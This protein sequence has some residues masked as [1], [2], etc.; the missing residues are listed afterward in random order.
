MKGR[1]IRILT[2]ALALGATLAVGAAQESLSDIPDQAVTRESL[3]PE[4]YRAF[5]A[6]VV[7]R[8]T[9]D[10]IHAEPS[11]KQSFV[12]GTNG[13]H[14]INAIN[15]YHGGFEPMG[16]RPKFRAAE[17]A[18]DRVVLD[19][20]HAQA[21][22]EGF[23]DGARI[24]VYHPI[25]GKLVKVRDGIVP[26]GGH[27]ASGW[28]S[29]RGQIS[30]LKGKTDFKM[31]LDSSFRPDHD[32]WFCVKAV[33]QFY[34]FSE[35]S[36]AVHVRTGD[37]TAGQENPEPYPGW[38]RFDVQA[39]DKP[40][41]PPAP[42]N[43]RVRR[44]GDILEFTWDP[45]EAEHLRGYKIFATGYAPGQ[46]KGF[47][48]VLAGREPR[49]DQLVQKHDIV[50]VDHYKTAL[51]PEDRS[52]Y[53]NWPA[54]RGAIAS[55]FK[56]AHFQEPYGLWSDASDNYPATW[57]LVEHP[58]PIP[59]A[60][61]G[62]GSTCLKW[63]VESDALTGF[64]LTP[65]AH[66]ADTWYPALQPGQYTFEA[67]VQGSGRAS[68]VFVGPFAP[69]GV[70]LPY[71]QRAHP[72]AEYH[73]PPLQ[74]PL[75]DQ[76][77]KV[78]GAFTVPAY[79]EEGL[80]W[81][82]LAFRGPG[83]LYL[84]N[85]RIY[86]SDHPYGRYAPLT[87]RRINESH[88]RFMRTHELI[89]TRWGYTLEGMTNHACGN[90]YSAG[91]SHLHTFHTLLENMREAGNISPWLQVEMCLS[92]Q[93]WLG[94]VEWLCAPYDPARGDTPE[95]KPWAYKRWA[96]GQ[97]KP[98]IE[99]F[100]EF[101]FEISN[102]TWNQSFAPYDWDWGMAVTDG[103]TG[104]RYSYGGTYG[105]FNQ[106]VIDLMRESPYWTDEVEKKTRFMLCG[107]SAAPL[108]GAEAARLCPAADQVTYASY[109]HNQGLG[110][111]KVINDFKRFYVMQW[112]LSGV[113]PQFS[114]AMDTERRLQAE[115]VDIGSGVYEYGYAYYV[116]P[117]DP[118]EAKE[119]DQR[120][121]RS[122]IG[123]VAI[124]DAAMT[125]ASLGMRD[126]AFFTFG[127][128]I[129]AW[130]SHTTLPYGGHAYPF[131]KALILFN[132]YGTGTFLKTELTSAPRW[133]FPAYETEDNMRRV[134]RAAMPDTP[135]VSVYATIRGDRVTVFLVSR[136]LD[137]FPVE[138]DAGFTPVTL[139]LPFDRAD[140]ITLHKLAGKPRADD[141]FEEVHQ[142]ETVP[143][144][145]AD[146]DGVLAVNRAT[147]AD[148]RGLPPA[149]I[150]CYVFEGTD[151][152]RVNHPPAAAFD[153]PEEVTAGRPVTIRN[154]SSDRDG[155][156]LTFAWKLGSAGESRDCEP[157]VNFAQ[158]GI[159]QIELTVTE[160]SGRTDTLVRQE[161]VVGTDFARN[162]WRPRPTPP[163]SGSVRA[164]LRDGLLE[165]RGRGQISHRGTY[166]VLVT[167]P[168]Y[169]E[170]FTFRAVINR[171]EAP[172]GDAKASAGVVLVSELNEGLGFGWHDS[173][174]L[175]TPASLLL[176]PDGAVH[177]LTG[178]GAR[179]REV[180]AAGSL[181]FPAELRLSVEDGAAVAAVK[182][183]RGWTQVARFAGVSEYGLMPGLAVGS[184]DAETR[185][186]VSDAEVR[187]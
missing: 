1:S 27:R 67:W 176:K 180:L 142:V 163:W 78:T 19:A 41:P 22:A 127:H 94:F 24:R 153:L 65:Y 141:R 38:Q 13:F 108:F 117:G 7:A 135:L 140:K 129:G 133:D 77:R 62:R 85:L 185:A 139:R 31:K 84:D 87:L 134:K 11:P 152:G 114:R 66:K 21:M 143:L 116:M 125:G 55:P 44:D 86:R 23:Y 89:K 183:S 5:K 6:P 50:F 28:M 106:Y 118:P 93:E 9:L 45:V 57:Q 160:P 58:D 148:P 177:V 145:P 157:T 92:E 147:G 181:S 161:Q 126:Q 165:L 149:A 151:V 29:T 178:Q 174:S 138:G 40:A 49:P 79:L 136:K 51:T 34:Q 2:V 156:P 155:G 158:A 39:A 103:A 80:G 105:L 113:K 8:V 173:T 4:A 64:P 179:T 150:F 95:E 32:Y 104:E 18:S 26:P 56:K 120:L 130:G 88:M 128:E 69:K 91:R 111:P 186:V 82:C 168:L 37:K 81:I 83:T 68:L 25:N 73:I 75:T 98:W 63:T 166:S 175:L 99:E 164:G 36:N 132:R 59:R 54:L 97:K 124:F 123:A 154:L 167:D 170:D 172:A 46:H 131:W 14:E 15:H 53:V 16:F 20:E 60:F 137:D 96:M 112:P 146:F 109:V 102:E 101:A 90:N 144:S 121:A 61:V 33:D 119:V 169:R 70:E 17:T 162:R 122:T 171:I 187:R 100:P 48:L 107:W 12:S 159:E 74:I 10:A 71:G 30:T 184:G 76:W 182:T 52:P 35:A 110:D 42:E 72:A 3:D 115:G 47:E 43:F